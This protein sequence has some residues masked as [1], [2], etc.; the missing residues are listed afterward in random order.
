MYKSR[1]VLD[2]RPIPGEHHSLRLCFKAGG[3]LVGWELLPTD[4]SQFLL[5]MW[6][7]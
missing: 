2:L 6:C 5:C 4:R 7:K 1:I 3:D